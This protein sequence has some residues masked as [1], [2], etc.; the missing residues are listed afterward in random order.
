[1][2]TTVATAPASSNEQLLC[3]TFDLCVDKI[4]A[5]LPDLVQQPTTWALA[6]DGDYARWNE[7]FFEIGNWTSGF[8]TGMAILAWQKTGDDFFL[9]QLDALEPMFQAKLE[10]E[11][12]VNTMHDIGFLYSPYAVALYKQTGETR[13]RDLALKAAEVLT[14]RFI[15]KGGYFRAWGRMDE[16]GTHYDGLAIIDCLMNMPLLY[17][18]TEESGDPK[19]RDMAIRHT[20]TTLA[21]FIREDDSVFHSFRFDLETGAPAH[22]DNYCGRG[23]DSHWARGTTWAMYGL[24]L[25][26]R[27]T[28]D[29]RYLDASLRVTRKFI[30]LLDD[31]IVPMWDFKLDEIGPR[32]RDAS[33][34]SVAVCALQELEKLGKAD[35]SM[36]ASKAALL[37]RIC[38]E[39]YLETDPAIRGIQKKGEVGD[40]VG[41]AKYAYT[42]W[43]DYYLMEGVARELGQEINWW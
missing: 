7:G 27:H 1:M 19:Y 8:Y 24:A 33:A 23:V 5:N 15:A 2:I 42:S 18:A 14:K 4:R 16:L 38:S 22:G 34:A 10:G 35:E 20:N 37:A 13:F 43:G 39:D 28:G 3:R 9:K 31:E 25:G 17:W 30:S 36:L 12:A 26:Y 32:I 40:G 6:V 29:V 21:N 11:N 41:K